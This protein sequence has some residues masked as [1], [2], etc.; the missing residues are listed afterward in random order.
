MGDNG[1]SA[2]DDRGPLTNVLMFAVVVPGVDNI[3]EPVDPDIVASE[4]VGMVNEVRADGGGF[5]GNVTLSDQLPP[6]WMSVRAADAI[7][8]QFG[9]K[10]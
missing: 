6:R 4:F 8:E 5:A 1:E 2:A 9:R 7:R 10:E 3:G